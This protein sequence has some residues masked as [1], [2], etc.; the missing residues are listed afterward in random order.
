MIAVLDYGIGNLRSAEKALQRVG[1]DA[2]LVS[3]PDQAMTADAVVLPGVGAFGRC[4]TALR[5]T[6]L[7][8]VAVAAVENGLP[9]LGI[10]IGL[11]VLYDGSEEDPDGRGLG[12]IRGTVRAL[13]EGQKHPQMQWN[14]VQVSAAASGLFAGCAGEPWLYFVHSFAPEPTP[15]VVATCDYGGPVVAAVEQ[16]RLWATQFHPEKSG[17]AGLAVL[18]N[19]VAAVAAVGAGAAGT[20]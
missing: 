12:L 14:R 16:G 17:E 19:F 10:C 13:P 5:A 1:G 7:D 20:R 6:G 18:G 15:E 4:M 9:F 3:D 2:H 8:K 11:Q